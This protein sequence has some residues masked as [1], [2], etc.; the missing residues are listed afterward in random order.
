MPFLMK[1][2]SLEPPPPTKFHPREQQIPK[3]MLAKVRQIPFRYYWRHHPL[4]RWMFYA[5]CVQLYVNYKISSVGK[6]MITKKL[7]ISSSTQQYCP[8]CGVVIAHRRVKCPNPGRVLIPDTFLF[9]VRVD[10]ETITGFF[11]FF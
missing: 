9:Q 10:E 2:T 5:W 7:I 1:L 3:T 4:I 11:L 6:N 8:I